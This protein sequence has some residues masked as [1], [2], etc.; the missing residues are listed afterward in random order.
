MPA[1]LKW[2][3][4]IWMVGVIAAAF[5][6]VPPAVGFADPES[7]R[8]VLFHVPC[9]MMAVVAYLVSTVYAVGYLRSGRAITDAKSATSAGLGFVFTGLATVSGMIFAKLQ[10]GAAWNWDPR[11][12][13]ILM[14]LIVYAAY[15]ALRSAIPGS[16][17]RGKVSAVYNILACL[18]MFPLVFVLPRLMGGL[19]PTD[20]L[21]S[22]GG[23]APQ[24]KIVMGSAM[25]G[26]LWLY[27]WI[28]RVRVSKIRRLKP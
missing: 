28:F 13:T 18:V 26:L 23:L 10:W 19:H 8:I 9:A 20:T 1:P 12:T 24:Y 25:L 21:S 2:G 6:Y 22:Q 7:A 4:G 11:Q 14:L 15:F 17:P 16:S 27:V 5:L 3:W